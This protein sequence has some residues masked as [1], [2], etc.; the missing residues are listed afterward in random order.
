MPEILMRLL[1]HLMALHL[2]DHLS[3]RQ[4]HLQGMVVEEG[5]LR[6]GIIRMDSTSGFSG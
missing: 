5:Q 6:V 2:P 1:R 4:T 3:R